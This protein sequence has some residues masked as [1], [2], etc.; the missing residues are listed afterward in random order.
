MK[1]HQF[2]I[3]AFG[4]LIDIGESFDSKV[5]IVYGE[6]ESGK[7]TLHQFIRA[8][9]FGLDK[10]SN[11]QY[12]PWK[13]TGRY[14]GYLEVEDGDGEVY[15]IDRDFKKS[16]NDAT[17]YCGRKTFQMEKPAFNLFDLTSKWYD[18]TISI[19]QLSTH[20]ASDMSS[21]LKQYLVNYTS[22]A[23]DYIDI[24]KAIW[25][26]DQKNKDVKKSLLE[27]EAHKV[28]DFTKIKSRYYSLHFRITY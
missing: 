20:I 4:Q 13:E 17:V 28:D 27:L 12:F 6:N 11:E 8:M 21:E 22:E 1:I 9:F 16:L 26:L 25:L 15:I 3:H 18:N 7:T 24:S 5:T 19:G 2:R 23:D 10:K 14:G